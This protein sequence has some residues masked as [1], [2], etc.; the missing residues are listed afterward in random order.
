LFA[1]PVTQTAAVVSA[2]PQ[3]SGWYSTP[4]RQCRSSTSVASSATDS[5]P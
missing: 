2:V 3:Y 5:S 1:P 4:F